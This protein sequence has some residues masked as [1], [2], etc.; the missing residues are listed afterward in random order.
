MKRLT[1]LLL[2]GLTLVALSA[3]TATARAS[4]SSPGAVYTLT[5]SAVGNAV[6]AF[7]RAADGTLTPQGTYAT[8]GL[9][10]GAALGSQGAVILSDNGRQLFAVPGRI[11]SP[12]TIAGRVRQALKHLASERITLNPDCGFAPGSGAVVSI[13]EAYRKLCNQSEA[14]RMLRQ[15]I[16]S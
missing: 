8:G 12:E 13:D 2:S 3:V 10:S 6:L 4:D 16:R 14:A 15:E 9:G 7:S 11:D 1:T 5:N